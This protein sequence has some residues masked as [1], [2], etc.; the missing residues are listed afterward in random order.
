MRAASA[1]ITTPVL[2]N[3]VTQCPDRARQSRLDGLPTK[4]HEPGT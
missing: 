2:R 4:C 3:E 1:L